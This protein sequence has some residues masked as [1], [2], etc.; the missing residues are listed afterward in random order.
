MR[1]RIHD[2]DALRGFALCGILFVNIPDIVRMGW[3][4]AIGVADPVRAA[5]N[6]FVQQRFHPIFAFLFGVG[7]ALLLHRAAGRV[8]RP[9]VLLLRRLAALAVIG[10][11]HQVLLPGEPLLI[12]AV[13]GVVVLL[14]TARLPRSAVLALAVVLLAVGL[15]LLQ[16]G[17]GLVPG[18]LLLGASAVRYGLIDTLDRR[19]GQL[20][21]VFGLS[22]ALA[23][24]GL[25]VQLNSRTDPHF[26]TIWATA[27]LLLAIA[28]A[29]GFLL[30]YRTRARGALDAVFA[31]LGRMA[32]TNFVTATLLTMAVG[33]LIGLVEGSIRYDR[34]LLLAVAVLGAQWAF[35]TWWLGRFGYGPLE[36]VWRC[37][38]WWRWLPLRRESPVRPSI[39]AREWPESQRH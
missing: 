14:P 39:G 16:G 34:M 18:L 13:V 6:V 22:A 23:P 33:P 17:V 30:L 3:G 31:P 9:R 12:Y 37:V 5:L 4:P 19:T 28:Y 8:A 29:S 11:G 10:A 32:L 38:T 15:L 25:W 26:M 27:G 1:R 7:F 36:W 20:A 21:I 35:S 24:V 2:L